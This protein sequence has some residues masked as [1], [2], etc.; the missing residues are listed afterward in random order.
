MFGSWYGKYQEL[1]RGSADLAS[2]GIDIAGSGVNFVRQHFQYGLNRSNCFWSDPKTSHG[3][4]KTSPLKASTSR[5]SCIRPVRSFRKY[6]D[7]HS[8]IVISISL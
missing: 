6:K 4:N 8:K 5:P 7:S 2:R 1:G 3:L